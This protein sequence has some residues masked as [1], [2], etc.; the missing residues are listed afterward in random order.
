MLFCPGWIPKFNNFVS[1]SLEQQRR[2]L[3]HVCK[4]WNLCELSWKLALLS[5]FLTS[6]Q[7]SLSQWTLVSLHLDQWLRT[8]WH[9]EKL[10]RMSLCKQMAHW[11]ILHAFSQ[12]CWHKLIIPSL[13][14]LRQQH[15]GQP[16]LHRKTLSQKNKILAL[17]LFKK[18][19]IIR[20]WYMRNLGR[21]CI[22]L[23]LTANGPGSS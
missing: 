22:F 9:P 19:F 7:K 4:T 18:I 20:D 23:R 21:H 13:R 6:R 16:G 5:K 3:K 10:L 11:C 14:K 12:M 1:I 2:V 17:N 15:Q 8:T